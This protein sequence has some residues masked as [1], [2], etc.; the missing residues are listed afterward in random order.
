MFAFQSI[1]HLACIRSIKGKN[2]L[3]PAL[4]F[5]SL[6]LHTAVFVFL[7]F[8]SLLELA[9]IYCIGNWLA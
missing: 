4:D 5:L 7:H 6:R 3:G 1:N 8:F 9:L 2:P